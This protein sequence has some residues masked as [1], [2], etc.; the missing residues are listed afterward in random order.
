MYYQANS[1]GTI[2]KGSDPIGPTREEISNK[3]YNML[4]S[5]QW[6]VLDYKVSEKP[7]EFNISINGNEQLKLYIYCWR[8]SNGGRISRPNEKRIQIS[9]NCN[10]IGFDSFNSYKQKTLLLGIYMVDDIDIYVA[11]EAEK[12]KNHG[13]SKSCFVDISSIAEAIKYGF[14]QSYD[15][16]KNIICVFQKEFIHYYIHNIESLHK[17]IT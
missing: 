11:W 12:N 10:S 1:D 15:A 5:H 2:M 8:I 17:R 3:I 13:K 14:V 9:S 4:N 16:N 7:F 6:K